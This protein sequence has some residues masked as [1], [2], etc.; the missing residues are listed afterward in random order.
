MGWEEFSP[1][2]LENYEEVLMKRENGSRGVGYIVNNET[3]TRLRFDGTSKA[4]QD[5]RIKV[6]HFM[7]IPD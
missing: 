5:W 2:K 6:T 7:R 4:L 3:Y 1:D